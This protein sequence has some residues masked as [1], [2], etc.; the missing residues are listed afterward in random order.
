MGNAPTKRKEWKP[1]YLRST[2]GPNLTHK[3]LYTLSSS[4][5]FLPGEAKYTQGTLLII[6]RIGQ[7]HS[8][9]QETRPHKKEKIKKNGKTRGKVPRQQSPEQHLQLFCETS[10]VSHRPEQL[11]S[12]SRTQTNETDKPTKPIN[13]PVSERNNRMTV[14]TNEPIPARPSNLNQRIKQPTN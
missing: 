9:C 5:L 6:R 10:A 4:Y 14:E 13:R 8:L 3:S 11:T 7:K 2:H 1:T 12:A